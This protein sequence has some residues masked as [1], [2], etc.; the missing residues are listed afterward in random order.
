MSKAEWPRPARIASEPEGRSQAECS[1]ESADLAE[2]G[3]GDLACGGK[4]LSVV[5]DP[6]QFVESVSSQVAFS[7]MRTANHRDPFDDE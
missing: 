2:V 4:F 3:D 5:L 6:L 7:T 1:T